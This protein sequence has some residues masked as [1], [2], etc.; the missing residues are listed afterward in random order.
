MRSTEKPCGV[1]A[2]AVGDNGSIFHDVLVLREYVG[3]GCAVFIIMLG[4]RALELLCNPGVTTQ[5]LLNM[6]LWGCGIKGK[7]AV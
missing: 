2:K 6:L 3:R 1:G 4:N 5:E 7:F